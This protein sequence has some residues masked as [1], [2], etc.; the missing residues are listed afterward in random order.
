MESVRVPEE[1][2]D[3]ELEPS[4]M[5]ARAIELESQADAHSAL[6][7]AERIEAARLRSRAERIT[8]PA[9][10]VEI[11]KRSALDQIRGD[12][13]LA[14]A[15]VEVEELARGFKAADLAR[16]LEIRDEARA[17]RL[18]L[19]LEELG[20]VER[21]E[22]GWTVVGGDEARVREYAQ[23]ARQ[24]TIGDAIRAL[25]L[26]E[27][28]MSDYLSRMAER[29]TLDALG[30]GGFVFVETAPHS[31]PRVDRRPPEKDPP[32]YLDAPKRGEAVRIVDHGKR[33]TATARHREKLRDQRHAAMQDARAA[34]SE[35]DRAK[36]AKPSGKAGRRRK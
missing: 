1:V 23:E 30:G 15:G 16:Q 3:R 5:L 33:A 27:L 9:K 8:D 22:G 21:V 36:S 2:D 26:G 11:R 13:L 18:I 20:K 19:A 7:R 32:A 6:A 10:R 12:G 34:R 14:A 29:G 4:A 25:G 17:A 24:F 28:E 35:K 31:E